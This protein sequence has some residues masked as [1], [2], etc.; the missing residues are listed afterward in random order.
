MEIN[1][2]EITNNKGNEL[3]EKKIKNVMFVMEK[4]VLAQLF[5]YFDTEGKL[6]K[7]IETQ[8]SFNAKFG[9]VLHIPGFSSHFENLWLVGAEVASKD[10]EKK[11]Y[12]R[13]GS[14][15]TKVLAGREIDEMMLLVENPDEQSVQD[16]ISG[17]LL[18]NYVYDEY[19][20][21]PKHAK[22][23]VKLLHVM[24]SRPL[25][26]A[27]AKVDA[28]KFEADSV[29]QVRSFINC[30]PCDLYPATF[31]KKIQDWLAPLGVN[32]K[33]LKGSQIKDMGLLVGVGQA[34]VNEPHVVV[35]EWQGDSEEETIAL[36][37]KGVTYDSGGLSLKPSNSMEGMKTDMS[38]SAIVAGVMANLAKN[39]SKKKVIGIVGLVENMVAGNAIKPDDVLRSLA[40]KTVEVNNTD[41]EGRLVL[42]DILHYVQENYK[43]KKIVDLATLTGAI[44][45]SLGRA[46]AGLF[47]NNDKLA[48]ELLESGVNAHEPLWRMPLNKLYDEAMDSPIADMKNCASGPVG[49]GSSTAAAFLQRFIQDD[50][51]WAHL[52]IAGVSSLPME[53]FASTT[54]ATGFG[55]RL[56]NEWLGVHKN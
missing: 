35:M 14:I 21:A 33:I 17:I 41:A 10:A 9:E 30:P 23:L 42:A 46:Y 29:K 48:A 40:G 20:E 11:N 2:T 47:S 43:P 39:K 55:V 44:V 56:L 51:Q 22:L 16:L 34:S 15:I 3:I 36:V 8:D 52:D 5:K 6:A 38:G 28:L 50:V 4:K 1:I 13:L 53:S 19:K 24:S 27:R 54:G 26:I 31:A 37:G 25:N 49:A 45:V 18:R 12:V 7:I 32:V